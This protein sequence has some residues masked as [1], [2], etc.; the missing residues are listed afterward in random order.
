MQLSTRLA[1]PLVVRALTVHIHAPARS[2]CFASPSSS[3]TRWRSSASPSAIATRSST[4]AS[5]SQGSKGC[6]ACL[7]PRCARTRTQRARAA[8]G[9]HAAQGAQAGRRRASAIPR[10]PARKLPVHGVCAGR[11]SEAASLRRP[12]R[13]GCESRGVHCAR[14]LPVLTQ[15]RLPQHALPSRTRLAAL[16]RACTTAA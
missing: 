9:A 14:C 8:G 3:A 2:A 16:S 12:G 15:R 4:H 10:R 7:A 1:L 6:A 13:G 5:Q 11:G